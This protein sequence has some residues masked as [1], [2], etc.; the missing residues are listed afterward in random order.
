MICGYMYRNRA[1]KS[2]SWNRPTADLRATKS[3]DKP[4]YPLR[5]GA[6]RACHRFRRGKP[7]SWPLLPFLGSISQPCPVLLSFF[8]SITRSSTPTSTS[9]FTLSTT[10]SSLLLSPPTPQDPP[11]PFD[12]SRSLFP[13]DPTWPWRPG[14]RNPK[15]AH[16]PS[17]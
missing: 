2:G 3:K 14:P 1:V 4:V 10:P 12:H 11:P 13:L 7:P 8:L 6:V 17:P 9:T 16:P 5:R 15:R